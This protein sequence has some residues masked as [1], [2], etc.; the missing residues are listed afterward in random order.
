MN[1]TNI[2]LVNGS[3]QA[4]SLR[5]TLEE[6]Q[7]QSFVILG[8][9]KSDSE[10]HNATQMV[11]SC[12]SVKS[13]KTIEESR[14]PIKGYRE[15]KGI[16]KS[17]NICSNDSINLY[18]FG[19]H[20]PVS[21]LLL[22]YFKNSLIYIFEEGFRSYTDPMPLFQLNLKESVKSLAGSVIPA[23]KGFHYNN[24]WISKTKD[25]YTLLP[26]DLLAISN[27]YPC[28]Q[29]AVSK[30]RVLSILSS[31][32]LDSMNNESQTKSNQVKHGLIIGQYYFRVNQISFKEELELYIEAAK[33][34][35]SK[36]L[37]PLWRG[38]IR[39]SDPFYMPMKEACPELVNFSTLQSRAGLP[40]EF[41]IY[42][43]RERI[44]V[45]VGIASS[46]LIYLNHFFEI[47][48]FTL[49]NDELLRRFTY[50]HKETV[51]CIKSLLPYWE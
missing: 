39:E 36:G 12:P 20:R 37:I 41:S 10:L 5:A 11:L 33:K 32:D 29:S 8:D 26:S 19:F 25:F 15:L 35:K 43:N 34:I 21:R 48:C 17:W 51:H 27:Q 6:L 50:P 28:R 45:A 4:L 40:L 1:S 16:L 49:V 24:Q 44:A 47:P 18:L 31:I 9:I 23:L 38:H 30:E 3:W 2:S 22:N 13:I 42:P 14:N 7:Q 46:S